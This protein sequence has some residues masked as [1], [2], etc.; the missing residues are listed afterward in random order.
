[1]RAS[2]QKE[3][4]VVKNNGYK[5]M[6]YEIMKLQ[7]ALVDNTL[8]LDTHPNDQ[9]ALLHHNM[10]HAQL[11]MKIQEYENMYGPMTIYGE[12]NGCWNWI[13]SPWPWEIEY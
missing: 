13:K 1:M 10:M 6:L 3:A 12:G 7:F 9:Q 11:K 4:Y 5:K 2:G 8:Y